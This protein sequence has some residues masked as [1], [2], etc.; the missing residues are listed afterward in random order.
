MAIGMGVTRCKVG[1]LI[2]IEVDI[3]SDFSTKKNQILA[4]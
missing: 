4:A 2:R 3:G 1:S